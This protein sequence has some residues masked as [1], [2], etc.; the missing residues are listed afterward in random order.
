MTSERKAKVGLLGL[1]FDLI[2]RIPEL[3][4]MMAEFGR[5]RRGRSRP[6]PRWSF[7]ACAI[8]ARRWISA[9]AGSRPR[10]RTYSWSCS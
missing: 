8:R 9:V 5:E 1:M 6:A 3:K 10:A 2:D 7:P 4:P